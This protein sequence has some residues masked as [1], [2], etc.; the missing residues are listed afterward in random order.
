[1]CYVL[2]LKVCEIYDQYFFIYCFYDLCEASLYQFNLVK[3]KALKYFF[4]LDCTSM[5]FAGLAKFGSSDKIKEDMD[6]EGSKKADS[7]IH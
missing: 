3:K 2:D 1:M 5:V 7:S 4:P 6:N